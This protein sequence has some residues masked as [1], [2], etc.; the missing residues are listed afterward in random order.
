MEDKVFESLRH[1]L[2]GV[3]A[4]NTVVLSGLKLKE[5]NLQITGE[6]DFLIISLQCKAVLQV[7]HKY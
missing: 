7:F 6:I 5:K 1:A 4:K 2:N 3:K